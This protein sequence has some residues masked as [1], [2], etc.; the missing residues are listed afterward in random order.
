MLRLDHLPI[1]ARIEDSI[2]FGGPQNRRTVLAGGNDCDF[3]S[4][5]GSFG[6][7][8]GVARKG[9]AEELREQGAD[10]VVNDLAELVE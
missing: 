5:S 6:F 10:L 1:D 3:E 8:I 4:V 2:Q 9:N 7:V